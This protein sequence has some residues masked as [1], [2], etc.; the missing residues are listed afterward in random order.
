MIPFPAVLQEKAVI[1]VAI[2]LRNY[3][4]PPLAMTRYIFV[5]NVQKKAYPMNKTNRPT[6]DKPHLP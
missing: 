1:Y 3:K 4:V 6:L 2:P 5:R